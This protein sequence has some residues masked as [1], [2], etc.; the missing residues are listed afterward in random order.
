MLAAGEKFF[1]CRKLHSLEQSFNNE[2]LFSF[3]TGLKFSM[4]LKVEIV[5]A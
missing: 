1:Y 5:V 3:K 2:I 4:F